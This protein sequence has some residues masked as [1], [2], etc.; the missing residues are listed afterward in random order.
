VSVT[1]GDICYGM[2]RAGEG[3]GQK[4]GRELLLRLPGDILSHLF[5][6]SM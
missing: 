3:G 5:C 4:L 1:G 6:L 2:G